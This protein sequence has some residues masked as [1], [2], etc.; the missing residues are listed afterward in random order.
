LGYPVHVLG[1]LT[2]LHGLF[3]DTFST[4]QLLEL[5]YLHLEFRMQRILSSFISCDRTSEKHNSYLH[6]KDRAEKV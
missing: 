2:L 5:N 1:Y 4:A 3:N 6:V